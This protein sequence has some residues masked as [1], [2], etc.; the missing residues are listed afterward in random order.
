MVMP[1]LYNYQGLLEVDKEPTLYVWAII[2]MQDLKILFEVSPFTIGSKR[3]AMFY[4]VLLKVML[5]DRSQ[6]LANLDLEYTGNR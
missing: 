3:G 2:A 1:F 6:K 4:Q 5:C